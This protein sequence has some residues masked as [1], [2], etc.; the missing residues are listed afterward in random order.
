[1]HFLVIYLQKASLKAVG[2][3]PGNKT[4]VVAG[5]DHL[6]CEKNGTHKRQRDSEAGE[7]VK[8]KQ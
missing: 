1:M 6:R 3:I 2:L 5:K 8:D 7:E 4:V